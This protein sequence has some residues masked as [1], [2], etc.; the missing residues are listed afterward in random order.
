MIV[1]DCSAAIEI[2]H[3]TK[4]GTALR[5]IMLEGERVIA[6]TFFQ[7]E[8]RNAFWKYVHAQL[9]SIE[10]ARSSVR[11]AIKYVDEFIPLETNIDESFKEAMRCNHP[12]YDMLYLTLARRNAATLLTCDRKLQKLCDDLGVDYVHSVSL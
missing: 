4:E 12:V 9:L 3:G 1:L 2:T 6:P 7:V 5:N 10:N 8:V 11:I